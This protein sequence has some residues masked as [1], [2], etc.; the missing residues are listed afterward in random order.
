VVVCLQAQQQ[1]SSICT[2]SLSTGLATGNMFGFFNHGLG[3]LAN[4]EAN[5]RAYPVSFIDKLDAENGDKV[6]LPPSALDRLCE[7]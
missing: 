6:F 4:F 2:T 3:P 7:Y 5:Y 1:L